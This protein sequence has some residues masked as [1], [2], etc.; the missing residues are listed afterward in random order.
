MAG[1]TAK[2][3]FPSEVSSV[4]LSAWS[5]QVIV[6][7][8]KGD[9]FMFALPD[10]E[11]K[12]FQLH[13]KDVIGAETSAYDKAFVS[14]GRDKKLVSWD[15]KSG[16]SIIAVDQFTQKDPVALAVVSSAFVAS[17]GKSLHKVSATTLELEDWVK[18]T[19]PKFTKLVVINKKTIVGVE[20]KH[21][22][23]I[24]TETLAVTLFAK[25][26]HDED[27]TD[28]ALSEDGSIL[29]VA[30]NKSRLIHLWD[31][32]AREKRGKPY[33]GQPE[34]VVGLSALSNGH[35]ASVDRSNAVKIWRPS[36]LEGEDYWFEENN[37]ERGL[38]TS[39]GK[40]LVVCR[41]KDLWVY[42][43]LKEEQ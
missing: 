18:K 26:A 3:I 13:T 38:V 43:L 23:L 32:Q 41:K 15:V 29:A 1:P 25:D 6:G 39:D 19:D 14:V 27:I 33:Y 17:S 22:W 5:G 8:K 42:E 21:L 7:T 20:G 40:W 28:L 24:D 11:F 36:T 12:T 30:S 34:N 10:G 9:I 31:F 35:F 37:L 4:S 2:K 16:R